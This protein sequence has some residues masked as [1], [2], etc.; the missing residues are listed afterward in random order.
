VFI[1]TNPR[2]RELNDVSAEGLAAW[3]E[4]DW[5]DFWGESES[6][7]LFSSDDIGNGEEFFDHLGSDSD[8]SRL[9]LPKEYQG[10]GAHLNTVG[11]F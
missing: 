11:P 7:V 2:P 8:V 1:N 4:S 5:R 6:G 3:D 9:E 10:L